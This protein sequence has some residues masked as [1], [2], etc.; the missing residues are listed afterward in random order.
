MKRDG[1]RVENRPGRNGMFRSLHELLRE[2]A[3]AALLGRRSKHTGGGEIVKR[4]VEMEL[5]IGAQTRRHF[6]A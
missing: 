6:H 5:K 2:V 4:F 1:F 3:P